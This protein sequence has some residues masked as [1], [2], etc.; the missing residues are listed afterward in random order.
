MKAF[1]KSFLSTVTVGLFLCATCVC[2]QL[3]HADDPGLGANCEVWA[4]VIC[5]ARAGAPPCPSTKPSCAWGNNGSD[6]VCDCF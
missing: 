4:L 2:V 5:R 1:L 6:T 3:S